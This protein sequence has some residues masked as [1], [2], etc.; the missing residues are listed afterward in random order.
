MQLR[1]AAKPTRTTT[2][3]EPAGITPSSR[4][5]PTAAKPRACCPTTSAGSL[6]LRASSRRSTTNKDGQLDRVELTK[7]LGF[8]SSSRWTPT[9]TPGF[10]S[11]RRVQ[12]GAGNPRDQKDCARSIQRCSRRRMQRAAGAGATRAARAQ[13]PRRRNPGRQ[14][15]PGPQG[16]REEQ[17]AAMQS[18]LLNA[19]SPPDF[20]RFFGFGTL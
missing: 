18:N 4:D 20:K 19:G 16:T 2:Q 9:R 6:V 1:G 14:H 15:R 3:I 8:K 11:P 17:T 5:R 12:E 7:P 13:P 10:A